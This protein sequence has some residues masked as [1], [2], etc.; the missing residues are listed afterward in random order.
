M[1][2]PGTLDAQQLGG[3][4]GFSS[5]NEILRTFEVLVDFDPILRKLGN[6]KK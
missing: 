5:K 3:T 4:S 6:E 2:L 1:I